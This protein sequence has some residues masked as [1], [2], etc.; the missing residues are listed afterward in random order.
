ML[1]I[2]EAKKKVIKSLT[3]SRVSDTCGAGFDDVITGK[4]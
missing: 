2:P 4:G 1:T 3:K